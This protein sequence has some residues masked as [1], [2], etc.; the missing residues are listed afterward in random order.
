MG[1]RN[2]IFTHEL[3]AGCKILAI[4]SPFAYLLQRIDTVTRRDGCRS[5]SLGCDFRKGTLQSVTCFRNSQ[6]LCGT[7]LSIDHTNI[8]T[9]YFCQFF[10]IHIRSCFYKHSDRI[11][12]QVYCKLELL[13]ISI[14]NGM[15]CAG[16]I[17]RISYKLSAIS[18]YCTSY[19]SLGRIDTQIF[20]F[21]IRPSQ[22]ALELQRDISFIIF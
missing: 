18:P 16:F 3:T 17:S 10:S 6:D 9:R 2:A 12:F 5:A 8:L 15:S 11:V 13:E 7:G 22:V 1:S 19:F 20:R 4:V 21:A 14:S